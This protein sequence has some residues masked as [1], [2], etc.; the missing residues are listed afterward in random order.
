MKL[1]ILATTI[2]AASAFTPS[3][4]IGSTSRIMSSPDAVVEE[5]AAPEEP[6]VTPINGWVPDSSKPCYGLPGAVAPLGF[7]DPLGFSKNKELVGAKRLREAE[8]MHGRVASKCIDDLK[9][10]SSIDQSL[11][12]ATL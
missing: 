11:T 4:K 7:F 10:G 3:S 9:H 6:V 1:A 12:S 8:V 2:A 5:D